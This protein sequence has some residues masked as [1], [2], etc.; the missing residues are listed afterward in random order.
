MALKR[1]L[2]TVLIFISLP[3]ILNAQ[4]IQTGSLTVRSIPEGALITLTG[5]V[6]VS[7]VS[8]ATFNHVL[9]GDYRLELKK[10]GYEN[11]KT[12][13][14]LD[15]NKNTQVDINLSPKTRF[16]AMAR[17][18]FIPGWG[19][20]YT[21]QKTKGFLFTTL[22]VG[23]VVAYLIADDDFDDKKQIYD[24][25]LREYDITKS[26]GTYED[27]VKI[28]GELVEAQEDAYDAEDIRRVTIG[29]VIG[30]WGLN[31][32]DALFLFPEE[33][34]TF[35]VKGLTIAPDVSPVNTGVTIS[36]DF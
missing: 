21:D 25:K 24:D 16:K 20:R 23:S 9:I 19:Q 15:P 30:V 26:S 5:E 22:A 28:H 7:G 4:G 27:L 3:L 32:L 10:Y 36:M 29:A 12:H 14:V 31:L 2:A 6:V 33:R 13:V 11:Y 17:S 34:G 35:S 18:L 8:P 1:I